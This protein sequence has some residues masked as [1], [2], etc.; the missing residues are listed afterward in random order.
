MK[1][2]EN[3]DIIT[4]SELYFVAVLGGRIISSNIYKP[5]IIVVTITNTTRSYASLVCDK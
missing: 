2:M 4:L 5:F 3:N 1:G